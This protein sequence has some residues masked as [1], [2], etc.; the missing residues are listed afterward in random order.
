MEHP[1]A[2]HSPFDHQLTWASAPP[3]RYEI[4]DLEMLEDCTVR[5]R[6]GDV[7]RM[8]TLGGGGWG[9]SA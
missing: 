5:L 7:L 2:W 4:G 9:S 1:A 3:G 8:L 6:V